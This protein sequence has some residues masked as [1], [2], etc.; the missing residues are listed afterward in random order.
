MGSSNNRLNLVVHRVTAIMP[1]QSLL[2][3]CY[4]CHDG[5]CVFTCY[6]PLCDWIEQVLA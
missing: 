4:S 2:N 1:A 5:D 6:G 3:N